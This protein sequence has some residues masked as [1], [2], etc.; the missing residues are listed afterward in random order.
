MG[1]RSANYRTLKG[2]FTMHAFHTACSAGFSLCVSHLCHFDCSLYKHLRK[3][4][5]VVYL[6]PCTA[7]CTVALGASRKP[8]CRDL[9]LDAE[10][11]Q[12]H[13]YK[14]TSLPPLL[15]MSQCMPTCSLL[16]KAVPTAQP[17]KNASK[18]L[19]A[20]R[21]YIESKFTA[22]IC[23]NACQFNKTQAVPPGPAVLQS[24]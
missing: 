5:F 14:A 19:K 21:R 2:A 15:V 20:N 16:T 7:V 11:T 4:H 17:C 9:S 23:S 8:P 10:V 6:C 13:Q 1:N 3:S 22:V 24:H 12:T 18:P